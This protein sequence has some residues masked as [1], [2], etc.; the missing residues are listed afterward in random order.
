MHFFRKLRSFKKTNPLVSDLLQQHFAYCE[1]AKLLVESREYPQRVCLD[2]YFDL[3]AWLEEHCEVSHVVGVPAAGGF[4]S[5]LGLVQLLAP[6]DDPVYS[7]A[8]EYE[9]YNVGKEEDLTCVKTALWFFRA[10]E[11]SFALLWYPKII[12]SGCGFQTKMRIEVACHDSEVAKIFCLEMLASLARAVAQAKT[13]RGKVLSLAE[14]SRYDGNV[15]GLQVHNLREVHRDD[16]ILPTETLRLLE[17]NVLRFVGQRDKLRDLGISTKKGILFY[18]PPGTGKTH[19]IHYLASTLKDHTTLLVTS[20]QMALLDEYMSLARLLQPCTIVLEDVDLIA[21]Q[22]TDEGGC[23]ESLLNKLLN[24]MDGLNED[25]DILFILTTNRVESLEK[26]LAAR[27]GRIDQAIEFP[28]PDAHGRRKLVKLYAA[29]MQI[30][31]AD[32]EY[33]VSKTAG[34][35]ASFIKELMRRSLQFHL[36]CRSAEANGD[37]EIS[38]NDIDQAI[39]ELLFAG[40]PLNRLLLGAEENEAP[41]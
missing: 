18:G 25:A 14:D 35:S 5:E 31:D 21:R 16:I 28:L 24:E 13:Y 29:G 22:R 20:E 15:N 6:S 38:Q 17:R 10:Q 9:S 39:D 40:G 4:M 2:A 41:G 37:I 3:Q 11:F 30:S 19:T 7:S 32:V 36:E 27:P 1:P 34:V 8:L 23:S 12:Q 26:A 33:A